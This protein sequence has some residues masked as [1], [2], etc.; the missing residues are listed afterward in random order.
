VGGGG[1]TTTLTIANGGAAGAAFAVYDYAAGADG[2]TADLA[3]RKYTV[4]AG[5]ALS[6]TWAGADLALSLH[7]P[8]GFVRGFNGPAALGGRAAVA[9]RYDGA[10]GR[11]VLS[12]T[13]TASACAVSV[14][15]NAYGLLGGGPR[16]LDAA[17]GTGLAVAT[18]ASGHW[19]DFTVTT[20][21]CG[22]AAGDAFARR[23]MGRM[24]TGRDTTTDPAMA[25]GRGDA[26]VAHPDVPDAFRRA[27]VAGPVPTRPS[28]TRQKKHQQEAAKDLD[29]AVCSANK[30]A[31]AYRG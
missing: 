14:V 1:G 16:A 2:A 28:M 6:D 18:A 21:G 20:T 27:A 10:G 24:E 25:R 9:L 29:D 12:A 13:A 22:D 19:Y 17:T 7:G 23:F 8:N 31:C 11:V 3:P 30:D 4:E 15:D 26:A 5:K